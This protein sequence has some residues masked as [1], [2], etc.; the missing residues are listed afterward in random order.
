MAERKT[1]DHT[2]K[3]RTRTSCQT[4]TRMCEPRTIHTPDPR[5]LMKSCAATVPETD[6]HIT[7]L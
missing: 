3:S 2:G 6:T 1:I 4:A 7:R 5:G